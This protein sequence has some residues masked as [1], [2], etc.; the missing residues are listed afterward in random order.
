VVAVS[1]GR[2]GPGQADWL[3]TGALT[4]KLRAEREGRGDGRT[5]VITVMCTDTSGNSASGTGTVVVPHDLRR[6]PGGRPHFDGDECERNDRNGQ[7]RN[8]RD[9]RSR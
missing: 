3:V 5:Y 7:G 1:L 2:P 9:R 8:D 6:G 4:L